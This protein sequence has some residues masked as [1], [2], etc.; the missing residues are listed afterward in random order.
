MATVSVVEKIRRA[1]IFWGVRVGIAVM[2][3]LV[4]L[5]HLHVIEGIDFFL[6]FSALVLLLSEQ[7]N[8]STVRFG[9]QI[10]AIGNKLGEQSAALRD[11][12]E[13]PSF[14]LLALSECTTDLSKALTSIPPGS[15]VLIEHFGLDMTQAWVYFEPLLRTHA[16]LSNVEYRLLM[17]TDDA[18]KLGSAEEEVKNWSRNIPWS[19]QQIQRDVSAIFRE[20]EQQFR[21][22]KFE[23]RHYAATPVV[24]GFRIARPDL[25]CYMAICRWGGL[26]CQKYEWGEPQ[27]HRLDGESSSPAV[28]DMLKIFDG[29]FGHYWQI[30]SPSFVFEFPPPVAR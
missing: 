6:P 14:K 10:D 13:S 4:V 23:V 8:D 11:L 15:P 24:H 5:L 30:G 18:S 3:V 20:P 17:L 19:V 9:A 7:L 26:D 21:R 1:V 29:Y 27:Y 2:V 16:N 22:V 12:I 28:R 25:R